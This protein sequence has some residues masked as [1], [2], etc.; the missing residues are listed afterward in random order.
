MKIQRA[1]FFGVRG[2]PDLTLD[3][4]DA[5]TGVPRAVVVVTGPSGSG[6]TR[7]MEALIAAKEAIRPYG[8]MA[9]GA[10]WIGAGSAAK[11]RVTFHLDE[12]ERDFAGAA[13]PTLEGEVIFH[14]DRTAAE[15][16]DGLR[17]VLGRYSHT[18]AHG[19]VDYFPVERRIPTFPPFPGFGS[20]EQRVVRL[21]KD[22]RK[23][24]FILPFL[25]AL[26][27]DGPR[28]ER[29]A[30]SLAAL[31]PS[32]RYV[33][34][35]SGEVIARCFSS[36]GGEPVTAAQL[37]H[38]EADAVIFAAT[39]TAI[40]LDHS[41]VFVDRPELHADDVGRL[42]AGLASLGQD[43]QLFLAGRPELIAAAHGA[44]VVNL[45]DA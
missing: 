24:G 44:H 20:A 39:A 13:S 14:P 12:A 18:P 36:H 34:D 31:S 42:V 7:M 3:L 8:A 29:F 21:G 35:P 43:N 37:S 28:R 15:A 9:T 22:Q 26:D 5:R 38:G 1:T 11:I 30:A 2:V 41:L 10:A 17:A 32:C 23:Y 40:G 6:K 33:P 27:S 16:D 4:T 45:K 25:R 19:K